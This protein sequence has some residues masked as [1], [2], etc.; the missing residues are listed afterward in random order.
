MCT[1]KENIYELQNRVTVMWRC[2]RLP[3]W[4]PVRL[5][6]R[7]AASKGDEGSYTQH[8]PEPRSLVDYM[9]HGKVC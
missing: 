1:A 3:R 7:L 8:L 4:S 5:V 9:W 6:W 2:Y